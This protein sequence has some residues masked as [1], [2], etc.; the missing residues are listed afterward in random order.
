MVENIEAMWHMLCG[1]LKSGL[2]NK[3]NAQL[4][5]TLLLWTK[6][7]REKRNALILNYKEKKEVAT[8]TNFP[9][10]IPNTLLVKLKKISPQTWTHLSQTAVPLQNQQEIHLH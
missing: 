2:T 5:D 7:N 3:P 4:F 6:S 9:L 8:H 1:G 10:F